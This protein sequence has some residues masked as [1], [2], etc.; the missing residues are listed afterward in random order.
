MKDISLFRK[1][2]LKMRT[3]MVVPTNETNGLIEWV[4]NLKGLRPIIINLM[5]VGTISL[6]LS[7]FDHWRSR[8][9]WALSLFLAL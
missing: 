6:V 9:S 5:K 4:G 7:H 2:G 8:V 3:Y 1:R